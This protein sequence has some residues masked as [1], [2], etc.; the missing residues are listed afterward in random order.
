M[1]ENEIKEEKDTVEEYKNRESENDKETK[2]EK[3]QVKTKTGKGQK[4]DR[5]SQDE[6]KNRKR[7]KWNLSK[8]I[9]EGRSYASYATHNSPVSDLEQQEGWLDMQLEGRVR[10]SKGQEDFD[11]WND[12]RYQTISEVISLCV[13]WA[14]QERNRVTRSCIWRT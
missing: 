1:F 8:Y 4:E 11:S 6:G 10:F 2:R 3:G 9:G 5:N 12:E 14:V 13:S 7:R